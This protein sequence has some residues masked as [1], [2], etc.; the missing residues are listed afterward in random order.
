MVRN[1][2]D[3]LEAFVRHHG[4]LVDRLAIVDHRSSDRTPEILES[5]LA[6]RFSLDVGEEASAVHGQG[7]VLTEPLAVLAQ[8]AEALV[9]E[10]RGPA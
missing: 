3:I 10:L 5:L 2:E 1:E 7:R 9:E 8:T 4:T 6:E